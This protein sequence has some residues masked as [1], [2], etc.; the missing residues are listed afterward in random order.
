MKYEDVEKFFYEYKE[1]YPDDIDKVKEEVNEYYSKA[2][3]LE[4]ELKEAKAKK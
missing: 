3:K 2:I 1:K 4:H